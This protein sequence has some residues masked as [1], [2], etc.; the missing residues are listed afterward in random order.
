MSDKDNRFTIAVAEEVER[1][2]SPSCDDDD[3]GSSNTV[4][5]KADSVEKEN[6]PLRE[7][8]IRL[9]CGLAPLQ[10]NPVVTLMGILIVWGLA[11]WC[12]VAPAASSSALADARA[13]VTEFFTWFYIFTQQFWIL[14]LIV[15]YVKFGNQKLGKETD[16]PEFGPVAYFSMIFSAGVAVGMFFYGASEPL[17]HRTSNWYSATKDLSDDARDMFA[18]NLTMYHWGLSAWCVYVLVGVTAGIAT[19]RNGLPMTLRSCFEPLLGV[20][21]WGW[22]G[23]II[24]GFSCVTVISGVCTSLGLGA[25]QMIRGLQVIGVVNSGLTEDELSVTYIIAIWVVTAAATVSVVSGLD[26]GIKILSQTAF[27]MALLLW[28]MVFLFDKTEFL[29]NLF[30]QETGY[31]FQNLIGLGM[32]TDAFAQLNNGTGRAQDGQAGPQGFENGWTIYYEAW[33][34]AWSTFVGMFLAR[35]SKGR[36]IREVMHYAFGGP[37][38]LCFLWFTVFGGS[39]LRMRRRAEEL[40]VLGKE[41]YNDTSFYLVPGSDL[42]YN[43]PATLYVDGAIKYLNEA[44]GVGPVCDF[45]SGDGDAAWFNLLMQYYSFGEFLCGLSLLCIFIYFVT[46]ADSA[47]LMVDYLASNGKHEHNG[48]QRIFWSA[49]TGMLATAILLAGGS[50]G[51]QGLQAASIVAA[52]PF[53]AV[54][55]MMTV[56]LWRMLSGH[57]TEKPKRLNEFPMPVLGG[58]FNCL[59]VVCSFGVNYPT[60]EVILLPDSAVV[61]AFFTSLLCPPLTYFRVLSHLNPKAKHTTQN[62]C[63]TVLAGILFYGWIVLL[64]LQGAVP[65]IHIFGWVSYIVFASMVASTRY[66]SRERYR[67]GGNIAED[68]F[69]ALFLYPQV[70]SQMHL[71]FSQDEDSIQSTSNL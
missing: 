33:W 67:V 44:P 32:H 68:F 47:A 60:S 25:I 50:A 17:Y 66:I 29:A 11:V 14:F 64:C 8:T 15:I 55:C 12:M 18:L 41:L 69:A 9:P 39:A 51:L 46:S 65:G 10:F 16:H 57:A 34:T 71:L 42:C 45:D 40:M 5:V 43:P 48:G 26:K 27:F 19:H 1:E 62:I 36:T 22:I 70:L 24:D 20:Y 54:L 59:E 28:V 2:L 52:L 6:F 4:K 30:V 13:G 21:T 37:L 38:V 56:S 49:S 53:T 63:L 7:V 58:V 35:V 31:Y 3:L 23:D 61:T